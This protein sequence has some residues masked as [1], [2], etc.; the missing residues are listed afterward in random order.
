MMVGYAGLSL[1]TKGQHQNNEDKINSHKD[2][3]R[4]KIKNIFIPE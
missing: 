1:A 4:L 3:C 2:V